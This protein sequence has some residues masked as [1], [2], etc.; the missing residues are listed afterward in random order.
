MWVD[1]KRARYNLSMPIRPFIP[2]TALLTAALW[3]AAA[4]AAE[5]P[6]AFDAFQ[7]D[8]SPLVAA[9]L[10][11]APKRYRQLEPALHHLAEQNAAS[12]A[13]L[14][15]N[16]RIDAVVSLAEFIL[17]KREK[18]AGTAVIGKGRAMIGLLDPTRGLDPK[19]ITAIAASYGCTSTI[20][21]QDPASQ[22]IRQ[23]ADA[24]L[25]DVTAAAASDDPTTIVVLGHG[26][27]EEI[28]SYSIPFARLAAALVDA[29]PQR[30][31]D[32]G[33]LVLICDDCYSADFLINLGRAIEAACREQGRELVSLPYCIAG[34]N[35][36]CVGHADSGEKFVPHFWKDVIELFYVR[37]PHPETVTL[38][39]FFEK[40]DNMMYGYG[41]APHVD[42]SGAVT[43]TLIDAAQCQDPVVFVPLDGDDLARLRKILGLPADAPLSRLLDI[44]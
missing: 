5:F 13:V 20:F 18:A 15:D 6:P 2:A 29:R 43:Y 11:I 3:A 21:K 32:L 40:V 35:R 33:H 38:G 36:N 28:Q 24:F 31:V 22:T 19:E 10:E 17:E 8:V 39:D 23:L 41:R 27:P 44:G 14:P 9:R 12:L 4:A 7:R 30:P 34:T 26:S 16:E 37:R 42:K 25:A 1:I